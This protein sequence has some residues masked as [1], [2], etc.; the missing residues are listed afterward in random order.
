MRTTKPKKVSMDLIEKM[1]NDKG[2]TF[3]YT[4]TEKAATYLLTSNNYLRTAAYRKNYDCSKGKYV[5]LDFS[6]LQELSTLDMHLRFILNKMCMDIEHFLKVA[7]LKDM[8][9]DVLVDGYDI[10]E[11]YLS[12]NQWVLDN[13]ARNSGSVF[14]RDLC[15]KYLTFDGKHK[16]ITKYDQCPIWVFIEIIPFG[17]FISFYNFYY[18]EIMKLKRQKSPHIRTAQ[19]RR[20][21]A[22]ILN[23]VKSVR[24]VC[25][26]NNCILA[27]LHTGKA[28]PPQ[29][30]SQIIAK[31]P[32][33][34]AEQRNRRLHSRTSMEYAC[35]LY[36]YDKIVTEKVSRHRIDELR[37]FLKNRMPQKEKFFMKNDLIKSTFSFMNN[38]FDYFFANR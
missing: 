22:P 28:A 2:I 34:S 21:S 4:T 20:L 14:V 38:V 30:I 16:S 11:K 7:L 15:D 10:V 26:H 18:D 5:N 8:E 31:I 36:A 17:I 13:I 27:E 32:T 6:H 29:E 23:I 9:S 24:N 35:L 12:K 37:N 19:K 1:K 25:S 33:I 3:K